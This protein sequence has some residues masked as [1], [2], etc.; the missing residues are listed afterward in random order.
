M[1]FQ[2]ACVLFFFF[3]RKLNNRKIIHTTILKH[4]L[5]EREGKKSRIKNRTNAIYYTNRFSNLENHQRNGNPKKRLHF[6]ACSCH[7]SRL[8]HCFLTRS[9][10]NINE[11]REQTKIFLKKRNISLESN[12]VSDPL[13]LKLFCVLNATETTISLPK[14]IHFHLNQFHNGAETG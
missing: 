1:P 10:N 2:L 9:K 13:K 7:D 8:F 14:S 6:L 3:C 5:F 11:N 4:H 12:C